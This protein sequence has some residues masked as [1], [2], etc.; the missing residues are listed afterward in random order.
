VARHD[1]NDRDEAI[2]HI[3]SAQTKLAQHRYADAI[4]KLLDGVRQLLKI[5]SAD[6]SAFRLQV[7]RL[8]DEAAYRWSLARPHQRNERERKR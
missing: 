1:R 2:E 7:D 3:Q 4:D 6:V 5:T 8:L